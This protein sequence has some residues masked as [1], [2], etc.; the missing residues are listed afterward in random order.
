MKKPLQLY[1]TEEEAGLLNQMAKEDNR[2]RK[3]YLEIQVRKMIQEY[4]LK[5]K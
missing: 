4:K 3:N 2:S 5:K 1:F